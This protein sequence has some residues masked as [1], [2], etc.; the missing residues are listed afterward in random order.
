MSDAP[1]PRGGHAYEDVAVVDAYLAHRHGG[2]SSPNE[3]MEEPAFL[4]ALGP[5]DGQRVLDLGCGDGTFARRVLDLGATD[6]LGI[7]GSAAMIA[8]ARRDHQRTGVRFEQ[9][10]LEDIHRLTGPFDV[11]TGRMSFHYVADLGLLL[12]RVRQLLA[13]GGRVVFTVVH[14]V[15]SCRPEAHGPRTSWTVDDYFVPGPRTRPWFGATATWHH[16][17]IEDHTRGLIDAGFRLDHLGECAPSAT[18]LADEPEELARRRR[19]PL[20]L[21]LA[22]TATALADGGRPRA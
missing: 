22:G 4:R 10:D 1:Q 20:I 12:G 21:L 7:D 3:V 5:M 18:L 13:P 14:P 19:V 16:R 2:T 15:I 9:G 6:Y 17:T 11:V 8:I